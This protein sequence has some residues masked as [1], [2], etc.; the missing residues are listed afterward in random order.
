MKDKYK[1]EINY[2]R[3][4]LTQKCQLNCI[5]CKNHTNLENTELSIYEI[6]RIISCLVNL[7]INK[8]RLTGGEPL[9]RDDIFEIVRSVYT[10]KKIHTI[11][12]T[13]NGIL[14]A[15]KLKG[16]IDSGLSCINVSLDSLK[17]ERFFKI[18]GY[19]GF[20]KVMS[21]IEM[22]IEARIPIKINVVLMRKFNED[23]IDDFIELTKKHKIDVRFIE[24]MP[25]NNKIE[26]T[27]LDINRICGEEILLQYPELIKEDYDYQGEPATLYRMPGYKGRIGLINPISQSFCKYCN[28]IR[29]Q[30]DGMIRPCLGSD[31][32]ISLKTALQAGNPEL[33]QVLYDAILEKPQ[34][35]QFIINGRSKHS[36]CQIGG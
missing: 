4:S 27:A 7:G 17:R 32:T 19:D 12:I 9:L 10:H 23:E 2:L 33:K 15:D 35:S 22:A 36:M 13:T 16:L 1:R 11:G 18:T 25:M 5:Y 34:N 6:N 3:L 29:I 28:R 30:S 24:L 26:K 31:K 14:L 20:D 21:G 8:V